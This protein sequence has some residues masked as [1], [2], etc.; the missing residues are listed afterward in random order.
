M[1]LQQLRYLVALAEHGSITAAAA[2]L[3]T[4]QTAVGRGIQALERELKV[5]LLDRSQ[6]RITLTAEGKRVV[7]LARRTLQE[8]AAI[9]ARPHPTA[10][11]APRRTVRVGT[12]ASVA[13]HMISTL[14][15]RFAA[16]MPDVGVEVVRCGD[17]EQIFAGVREG[18]LDI[19][20]ANLPCPG[21]LEADPVEPFEVV[22][23]SPEATALP[24]PVPWEALDGLPMILPAR[25][26]TRRADLE[27][28]FAIAGVRPKAVAEIDERGAW[29]AG[30][31]SG[32]GSLFWY[33]DLVGCFG[34]P[35]RVR[36]FDPPIHRTMGLVTARRPQPPEVRAF[37]VF[38]RQADGLRR[39]GRAG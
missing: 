17:R 29:L 34:S 35:V 23:V 16:L 22:L 36:R 6:G 33:R 7:A 10:A 3:F 25:S 26:G 28:F 14:T 31:T 19:G 1:T 39:G 27:E 5:T 13:I 30:V 20:L 2:A 12:T 11:P 24:D 4:A 15:P 37:S 18:T 21:D 32:Q 8:V 9:G 38:A